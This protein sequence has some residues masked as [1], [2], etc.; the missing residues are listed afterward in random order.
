MSFAIEASPETM[1]LEGPFGNM[2]TVTM[3]PNTVWVQG[4]FTAYLCR[5]ENPNLV[6]LTGDEIV[7][8]GKNKIEV[9]QRV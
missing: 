3:P 6:M 2:F 4:A 1:Q 9:S 5:P 7:A 8:S